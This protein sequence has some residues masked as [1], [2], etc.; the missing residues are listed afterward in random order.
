MKPKEL[1][2]SKVFCPAPWNNL[3]VAPDGDIKT[4][5]IGASTCGN[6]NTDSFDSCIKDNPVLKE[7]QQAMIDGK[8]HSNCAEC[9][10]LETEQDAY[11]QR[12]HFKQTITRM[13][14]LDSYD[15]ADG[16][17]VPT[18]FDL[19]YDNTCQNACVYCFPSLS[20]R[21]AKELGVDV[22]RAPG[23]ED[24]KTF[25]LENL[26]NAKEVY[27]AGGEP[28]INKDFAKLLDALYDVNPNCKLRINSNI[29]NIKTPVYESAKRFKNLQY[30]ISVE[31]TQEQ[32]EYIRYP[33]KWDNF[34]QNVNTLVNDVPKYNF[35]MVLNVMNVHSLFD[36]LDYLFE[37]KMHE[38]SFIITHAYTPDWTNINHLPDTMLNTF[39]DRCK[40]YQSKCDPKYSLYS[41]LEGCI[42][43]IDSSFT[44]D[45][46]RVRLELEK[47]DIRRNLDSRKVFPY[48]Y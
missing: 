14:A 20:S 27:L 28:L 18:G 4:C 33:Q 12:K 17:L 21:W 29:K 2:Y 1:F 16:N 3:Y 31:S 8:Y 23:V 40:Q 7:I 6:L 48:I 45:I 30:T 37:M 44:K 41:A 25:V 9:Y 39:V 24:V 46:D 43:F 10:K 22:K 36:C 11:S 47:L 15:I 34:T 42:N 5:S 26:A 13:D 38:N 19:R 35:N 32:F